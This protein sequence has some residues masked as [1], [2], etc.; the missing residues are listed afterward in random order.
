MPENFEAF[1]VITRTTVTIFHRRAVVVNFEKNP[2]FNC[3]CTRT[4]QFQ[5]QVWKECADNP[6]YPQGGTW[7]FD[8]RRLVSGR[9]G[10]NVRNTT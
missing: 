3:Q 4:P 2:L 10:A 9:C 7:I 5:W 6:L 8:G 1:K